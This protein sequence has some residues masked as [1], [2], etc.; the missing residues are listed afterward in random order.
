MFFFQCTCSHSKKIEKGR[1][2]RLRH[3]SDGTRKQRHHQRSAATRQL[4][5][6]RLCHWT[7]AR[8]SATGRRLARTSL[9]LT[10]TL[11]L[12]PSLPLSLSLSL[13]LP[14]PLSRSLALSLSLSIYLSL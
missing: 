6:W 10:H 9:S 14:L 7:A 11:P 3:P 12:S 8:T 1:G 2:A 4:S 13:S 5:L